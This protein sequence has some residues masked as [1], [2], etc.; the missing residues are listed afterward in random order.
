[1]IKK[2][3]TKFLKTMKKKKKGKYDFQTGIKLP[4]CNL[5]N[6]KWVEGQD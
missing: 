2:L 6:A 4:I 5:G 1:M 3:V